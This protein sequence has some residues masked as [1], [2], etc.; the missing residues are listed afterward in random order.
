MNLP[1]SL[2]WFFFVYVKVRKIQRDRENVSVKNRSIAEYNLSKQ[3]ILD[4]LK[5]QLAISYEE[6]NRLKLSL[7]KDIAKMG[8]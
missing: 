3:P 5:Q 2:T 4:D 8:K 6:V 1:F 7:G